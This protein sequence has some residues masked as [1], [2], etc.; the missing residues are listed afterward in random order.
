MQQVGEKE[1]AV[2]VR[3]M[4]AEKYSLFSEAELVE[5]VRAALGRVRPN[6]TQAQR[7]VLLRGIF[8]TMRENNPSA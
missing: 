2:I 7:E 6:A 1:F 3:R 5:V 4:Q 8:E